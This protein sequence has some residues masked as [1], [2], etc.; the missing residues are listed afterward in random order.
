MPAFTNLG[1]LIRRDLD[2]DKLA[3]MDLGGE[4]ERR[5]TYAELDAIANGVARGLAARGFPRGERIAIL[6]ANRT[7]FI[8]ITTTPA[9]CTIA[10]I[11]GPKSPAAAAA[12][13]NPANT[14]AN[15]RFW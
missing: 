3:I 13:A 7:E 10:A 4:G 6:S 15:I 11:T 8:A 1:D 9:I 14:T 12:S 5:F 2:Q